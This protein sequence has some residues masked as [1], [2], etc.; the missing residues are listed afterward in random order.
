M[1]LARYK[2]T[3][4]YLLSILLVN[5]LFKY[6]PS[7]INISET[8]QFTPWTLLVGGWFVLRDYSQREIGHYVFI[9]MICGVI[10]AAIIS[11]AIALAALLA[12]GT[13]EFLDWLIYTISKKPFYKRILLSSLI[14]APAD[15]LI[16][17][18]AFD[19]FQIIPGVSI[20][21]WPT[22]MLG[23]LSKLTAAIIVYLAHKKSESTSR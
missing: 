4:F 14:S 18:S 5:G 23:I 10:I 7:I 2:Y 15:T 12:S 9:P 13:S 6:Y 20:F 17:F 3:A 11:P 1:V 22:V 21:N 19:Y 8:I 16:F